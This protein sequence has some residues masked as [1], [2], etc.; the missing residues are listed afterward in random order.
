[1]I[2][3]VKDSIQT[4]YAALS[5]EQLLILSIILLP[6]VIL[7]LY[8]YL[9][10]T[11][12]YESH[13]S[14]YITEEQQKSSSLDLEMFGATSLGSRDILVLKTFIDSQVMMKQLDKDLNLLDHFASDHADFFSRLPSDAPIEVAYGHYLSRIITTYNEEAQLLEISVQTFDKDFSKKVLD[15]IMLHSQTFVDELNDKIQTSSLLFYEKAVKESEADMIK[16]RKK[17]TDFQREN[18][19]FSTE[20]ASKTIAGTISG[21]EA[22]LA[23]KQAELRSRISVLNENAPTVLRIKAE[24]EA[25]REQIAKETARLAS[26]DEGA[27]SQLDSTFK[28]IELEIESKAARYQSNLQAYEKARLDAARQFRFLT[29]VS[30]PTIAEKSLFPDRL[31]IMITGS[32]IVIAL[33]FMVSISLSVVRERA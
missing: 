10:L 8:T 24:I 5:K 15:R 3:R 29:V 16:V 1:M 6:I 33:Y 32:I 14:V 11:D 27:L 4:G 30:A 19:I 7:W 23:R 12:R 22:N 28:E 31:Y 13:A 25:L 17:L 2:E 18:S 9:I 20:I 26:G 21:L